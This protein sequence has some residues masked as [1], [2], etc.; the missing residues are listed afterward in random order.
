[1][2]R[3]AG[4]HEH[5]H[6]LGLGLD[7]GERVD[8]ALARHV[9]VQ[10]QHVHF[11]GAHEIDRLP[12]GSCLGHHAD[13]ILLVEKAA[14]RGARDRMVVGDA[15]PHGTQGPWPLGRGRSGLAFAEAVELHGG[16][17]AS[18]ASGPTNTLGNDAL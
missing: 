18:R 11:L 12:A 6:V 4:E 15:H 7:H 8:A 1:V 10:Q 17:C 5:G 3:V 13:A 16:S 14:Q 9:Q 2:F